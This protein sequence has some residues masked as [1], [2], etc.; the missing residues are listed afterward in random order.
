ME[1]HFNVHGSE[2]YT[3]VNGGTAVSP[4]LAECIEA[5]SHNVASEANAD[6]L[7]DPSEEEREAF[8]LRVVREATAALRGPGDTYT[9]PIG[10]TWTLTD[11]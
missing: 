2:P 1:L 6:H 10:V 7:A 4:T 9:D 11:G 3:D 8:R 5:E